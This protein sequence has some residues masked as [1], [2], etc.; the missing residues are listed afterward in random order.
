M[1]GVLWLGALVLGLCWCVG[2]WAC[3]FVFRLEL[4]W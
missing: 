3:D 1:P 4:G 2:S